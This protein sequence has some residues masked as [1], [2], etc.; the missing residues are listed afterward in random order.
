MEFDKPAPK[1]F[2]LA[3]VKME[4]GAHSTGSWSAIATTIPCFTFASYH[5]SVAV[6]I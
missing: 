5:G 1:A 4:F 6:K 2:E 3:P